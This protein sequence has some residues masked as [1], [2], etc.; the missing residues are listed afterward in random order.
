MQKQFWYT[1]AEYYRGTFFPGACFGCVEIMNNANDEGDDDGK[2]R[3][4]YHHAF[5]YI[6]KSTRHLTSDKRAELA[7]GVVAVLLGD[8][9][10]I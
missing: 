6:Q 1:N 8:N 9:N 2:S 3:S 7:E 10:G 4:K 5:K